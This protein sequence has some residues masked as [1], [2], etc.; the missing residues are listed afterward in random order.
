MVWEPILWVWGSRRAPGLR[1][2][3][4]GLAGMAQIKY[5]ENFFLSSS[6]PENPRDVQNYFNLIPINLFTTRSQ[7]WNRQIR[8][9]GLFSIP[10]YS[11]SFSGIGTAQDSGCY[12]YS[13]L[14]IIG[15]AAGDA[16]PK[17]MDFMDSGAPRTITFTR[18]QLKKSKWKSRSI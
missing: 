1:S 2:A 8:G 16:H 7:N 3:P 12:S 11:G 9:I 13:Y 10:I 15:L 4:A 18:Y 14:F 5:P 6:I 17:W